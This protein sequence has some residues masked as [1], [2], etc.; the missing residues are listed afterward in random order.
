MIDVAKLN[1]LLLSTD[2]NE[3]ADQLNLIINKALD[4]VA[5]VRSVNPHRSYLP[6][7]SAFTK[8]KMNIRNNYRSIFIENRNSE[9]EKLYR[10]KK[11]EVILLQ[12][13]DKKAWANELFAFPLS[14]SKRLWSTIKVING[15]QVDTTPSSLTMNGITINKPLEI[16]NGLNCF[17]VQKVKALVN[18]LPSSNLEE[19]LSNKKAVTEKQGH[20]YKLSMTELRDIIHQMK[21]SNTCGLDTISSRV[22]KDC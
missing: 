13:A 8:N 12:K 4:C 19:K 11:R 14:D 5:P 21:T 1:S 15:E 16:A 6:H 3:V 22:I 17:F 9:N 18:K 20:L 2:P 10:D 7:L